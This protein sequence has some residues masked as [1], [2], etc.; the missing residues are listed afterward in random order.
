MKTGVFPEYLGDIGT[1]VLLQNLTNTGRLS[2][3]DSIREDWPK[4]FSV[5]AEM[6]METF[7]SGKAAVESV[8]KRIAERAADNEGLTQALQDPKI[9]RRL[10]LEPIY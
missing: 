3:I 7:E 1:E 4:G 9:L 6:E 10:V 5:I 8:E 2:S